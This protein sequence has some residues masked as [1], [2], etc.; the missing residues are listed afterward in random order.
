MNYEMT[1]PY[2]CIFHPSF[3]YKDI[4]YIVICLMIVSIDGLGQATGPAET[5][6]TNHPSSDRYASFSPNGHKIVFESDRE[7]HWDIYVMDFSGKNLERLTE[8]VSDDRRPSWH[9][10]GESILFESITMG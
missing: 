10:D 3:L 2:D 5:N 4:W 9:P 6:L 7:G 8:H 1:S